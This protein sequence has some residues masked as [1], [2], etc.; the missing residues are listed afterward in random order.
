MTDDRDL[1]ETFLY[2][3]VPDDEDPGDAAYDLEDS[4][5]QVSRWLT[6]ASATSPTAGWEDLAKATAK[7]KP[8]LS[9]AAKRRN[10]L[11]SAPGVGMS[12]PKVKKKGR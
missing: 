10:K 1:A 5:R 11:A 4:A 3:G 9:K 12:P 6:D 7:K 2:V 8:V